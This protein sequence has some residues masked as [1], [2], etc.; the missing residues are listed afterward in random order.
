VNS[1]SLDLAGLTTHIV[2]PAQASITCVLL[3]GFGAPGDDLLPLAEA[4]DLP[5]RFVFPAAPLEL[6]MG[7]FYGDSRAWWMLDL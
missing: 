4:L 7:G 5:V 2:G 6:G 1:T 3:H